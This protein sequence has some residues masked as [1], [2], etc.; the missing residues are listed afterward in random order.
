MKRF[1]AIFSVLAI[2][3]TLLVPTVSLMAS[4]GKSEGDVVQNYINSAEVFTDV[5][6]NSW[7]KEAVDYVVNNGQIGRAHV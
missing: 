2:M 3:M 5:K 6:N 1:L 7:F 4:D